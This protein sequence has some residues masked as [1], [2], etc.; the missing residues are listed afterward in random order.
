MVSDLVLVTPYC[1]RLVW[2]MS[3]VS[4][5]CRMLGITEDEWRYIVSTHLDVTFLALIRSSSKNSQAGRISSFGRYELRL[6]IGS[7]L[8][9]RSISADVITMS[10]FNILQLES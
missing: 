6:L 3:I 7:K 2:R 4:V 1:V 9:C 8:T 10:S 5:V